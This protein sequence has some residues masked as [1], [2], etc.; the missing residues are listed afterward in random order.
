MALNNYSN[1]VKLFNDDIILTL[2]NKVSYN[3][4]QPYGFGFARRIS[5][6]I[7]APP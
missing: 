3:N 4:L 2:L 5:G 7:K 6:V 1:T